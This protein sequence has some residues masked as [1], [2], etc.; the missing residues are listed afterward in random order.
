MLESKSL[1]GVRVLT[2]AVNLPGP[3]AVARLQVM[4]AAVTKIEPPEGDPLRS[5]CP[6]WYRELTQGQQVLTVD[7]K[8][9]AGRERLDTEL[10]A[11]DLLV[12]AMR[13]SA[14][15]RLGLTE[16]Q[17]VHPR[18]AHVEIVGHDGAL[19]DLPGHDL[20]YQAVN[21]TL[22]PPLMPTV[23]VADLLGAERAVSAALLALGASSK[24]R[25]GES[26]RVVLA[27][28]AADAG[29]AVRHG[30]MGH[31]STPLGGAVPGYGIYATS[32]GHIALAALEPHFWSRTRDVLGVA[33]ERDELERIFA[34]RTSKEWEELAE[35]VDIPLIGIQKPGQGVPA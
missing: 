10:A 9:P 24:P 35:R 20:T 1:E 21:G 22:Q 7:L 23:P 6:Q 30:L 12:T 16:L 25:R 4:G 29:A 5:A 15:R 28:A 3:L 33:G 19:E 31:S 13:P 32:D 11:S 2:L 18:L 26:Y 27:D 34:T 14:L 8:D 17:S